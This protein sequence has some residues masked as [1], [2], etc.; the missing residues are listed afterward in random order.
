ML[1][2]HSLEVSHLFFS[3]CLKNALKIFWKK[4][5]GDPTFSSSLNAS[6]RSAINF[7]TETKRC[8]QRRFP[9][10]FALIDLTG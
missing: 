7:M 8:R 4:L 6:P 5:L 9:M 3:I 1:P 2:K 10:L